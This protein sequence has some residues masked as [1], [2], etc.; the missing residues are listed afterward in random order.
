MIDWNSCMLWL[1]SRHF[2]E[3]YWW[4]RSKYNNDGVV[5]KAVWKE[6][7][8][9]FNAGDDYIELPLDVLF[10][11]EMSIEIIFEMYDDSDYGRILGSSH[12]SG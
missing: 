2:S 3:S 6:D 11:D 8:F 4:D 12:S 5:H 7:A 10:D 1:D 9:E